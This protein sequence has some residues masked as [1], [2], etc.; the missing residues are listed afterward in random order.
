[1]SES[2]PLTILC[3]AGDIKGQRFISECKRHGCRV[4]VLTRQS[5]ADGDWPRDDVD[6]F[7]YL[8]TLTNRDAALKGVSWLARTQVIDRIVGLDDF[9]VETA[10]LLRE[11]LRIPGMGDTT[12]RYFRDKL[13]MRVKA[14]E[15][16]LLVPEFIHLLNHA[17][18][19]DYLDRVEPPWMLKPRS[20]AAAAG[21]R[22]IMEAGE[23]WRLLDELSDEQ[24]FYLLEQFVPGDIYHVDSIVSEREVVFAEAHKYGRPPMEV[25]HL[26]GIFVTC[27]VARDSD[28]AQELQKLNHEVIATLG[29]VRGVTHTEFIK[30]HADGRFH[31][32][33]TGARVGGAHIAEVIEAATG[34][35]LWAEWA[36]IEVAGS[37]GKYRLPERRFCYAGIALCLARQEWPDTSLYDDPEV[38]WRVNRPYHAGLVAASTDPARVERLLE[39]YSRRFCEDFLATQPPPDRMPR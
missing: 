35:N 8:P 13:A 19:R 12:A 4:F 21:I 22:K 37:A 17:A 34:I 36:K 25:A 27:S 10:A 31:F 3:L 6:E 14:C 29:L 2:R 30:S 9:D 39:D 7:F 28:D 32:L 15:S 23:L 5:L 1:M 16:G 18:I 38:V 24:S 20:Q 33:E 26:G 11:H